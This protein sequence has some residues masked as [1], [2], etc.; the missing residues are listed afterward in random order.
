MLFF[1][2]IFCKNHSPTRHI[3]FKGIDFAAN[4]NSIFKQASLNQFETIS[5]TD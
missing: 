4:N 1:N 3:K 2:E 5:K